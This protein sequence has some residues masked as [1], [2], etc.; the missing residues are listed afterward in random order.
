MN[1]KK[2]CAH[3]R[4]SSNF[5]GSFNF[6]PLCSQPLQK[7]KLDKVVLKAAGLDSAVDLFPT[8]N[9]WDAVEVL[10]R[11]KFT[12]DQDCLS[13]DFDKSG[14][15]EVG[16]SG[17]WWEKNLDEDKETTLAKALL[18]AVSELTSEDIEKLF[19]KQA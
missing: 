7:T 6:C 9:L 1:D 11:A 5:T 4:E 15:L 17:I 2:S 13:I 10:K 12:K 18:W 14:N 8:Q 16:I 19:E 3:I